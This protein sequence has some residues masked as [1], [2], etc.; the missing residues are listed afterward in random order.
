MAKQVGNY[1]APLGW[2]RRDASGAV[3]I[4]HGTCFF[5]R[6][7]DV[8]FGVTANHVVQ[9]FEN[10]CEHRKGLSC[11]IGNIAVPLLDRMISRGRNVDIATFKI[12]DIE[13]RTL[14]KSPINVWPP[15]MPEEG[16]GILYGGYPKKARLHTGPADFNFGMMIC[17]DMA[18]AVYDDRI[19][20][21]IEHDKLVD[22][23]GFGIPP[24]GYDIGGMSGGPMLALYDGPI[25]SLRLCGVIVEGKADLDLVYAARADYLDSRGHVTG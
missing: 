3:D 16:R 22:I 24:S 23:L 17:Q 8:T 14:Q 5:V 13:I 2:A 21:K 19:S 6:T 18:R 12:S 10:Y 4:N 25:M 9:G 15:L 7:P 20:S 1:I 11:Q